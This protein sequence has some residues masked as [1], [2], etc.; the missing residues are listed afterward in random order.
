[1]AP[2]PGR[3]SFSA[4]EG[5]AEGQ[6]AAFLVSAGYYPSFGPSH[7]RGP[8]KAKLE[9]RYAFQNDP[10]FGPGLWA[11]GLPA[12]SQWASTFLPTQANLREM[13]QTRTPILGTQKLPIYMQ[14]GDKRKVRM[15]S[16]TEGMSDWVTSAA[17]RELSGKIS[18]Q[19]VFG[20]IHGQEIDVRTAIIKD[21]TNRLRG[22]LI[23][24]AAR[25]TLRGNHVWWNSG[26]DGLDTRELA[27]NVYNYMIAENPDIYNPTTTG[28]TAR[29]QVMHDEFMKGFTNFEG[30][31][32]EKLTR[33]MVNTMVGTDLAAEDLLEYARESFTE[34]LPSDVPEENMTPVFEYKNGALLRDVE[35]LA[36][37]EQFSNTNK[38]DMLLRL[39]HA[40]RSSELIEMDATET[41]MGIADEAR[42]GK[43]GFV[44][45]IEGLGTNRRKFSWIQDNETE[46]ASIIGTHMIREIK[47]SYNPVIRDL[48]SYTRRTQHAL[49]A[50]GSGQ[51][52]TVQE[53][54]EG[55]GAL[56]PTSFGS[57]QGG[58]RQGAMSQ[59][60][61]RLPP[62]QA[63]G[64]GSDAFLEEVAQGH[65]GATQSVIQSWL[66]GPTKGSGEEKIAGGMQYIF[67]MLSALTRST[68]RDFYQ[69]H[70]ISERDPAGGFAYYGFIPMSSIQENDTASEFSTQPYE[71]R[72]AGPR[73]PEYTFVLPGPNSALSI[74]IATGRMNETQ[75]RLAHVLQTNHF[76]ARKAHS[77]NVQLQADGTLLSST[78]GVLEESNKHGFSMSWSPKDL[79]KFFQ[80]FIDKIVKGMDPKKIAKLAD[81]ALNPQKLKGP[82][83]RTGAFNEFWALPYIG[84]EDNLRRKSKEES[85]WYNQAMEKI[86]GGTSSYGGRWIS[87]DGRVYGVPG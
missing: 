32:A 17:G 83:H 67:K 60:F 14:G 4:A 86:Y 15:G 84:F 31:R 27:E 51:V 48:I 64:S 62:G 5:G 59:L 54:L 76:S 42:T 37:E 35:M 47:E 43:H 75:A 8:S 65:F 77:E 57:A 50:P 74:A 56:T 78:N 80:G 81:E 3:I 25:Y 2:K 44:R 6:I 63:S 41:L 12:R 23:Q 52:P 10:I 38:S 45:Q 82:R 11:S 24:E 71:F 1:M 36:A 13:H 39:G 30:T 49:N 72:T 58:V 7:R 53:I 34:A 46:A 61:G 70:R 18:I 79:N 9:K 21:T 19:G 55:P 29:A 66:R 28:R 68:D 85:T 87:S 16:F 26:T 40:A 20:N 69:T 22:N 33:R 73:S